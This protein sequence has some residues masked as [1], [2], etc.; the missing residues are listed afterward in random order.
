MAYVKDNHYTVDVCVEKMIEDDPSMKLKV[1]LAWAID[2][3]N[4]MQ[5]HNGLSSIQLVLGT[6]PN[7][8]SVSTNRLSAMENPEKV[9]L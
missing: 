1:A 7:L 3:K 4:S 8:P 2:A 9:K 5:N 6:N